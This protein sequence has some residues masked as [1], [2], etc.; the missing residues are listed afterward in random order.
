[1]NKP[2]ELKF[3]I[4]SLI[5]HKLHVFDNLSEEWFYKLL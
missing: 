5:K 2:I 1:M 3:N 4:L